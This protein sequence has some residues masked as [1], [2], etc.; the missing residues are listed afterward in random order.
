MNPVTT[1]GGTADLFMTTRWTVIVTACEGSTPEAEAALQQLCQIYWRPL[2][3]YVRH[4]GWTREDAEDLTQALF[5]KLLARA[6][7]AELDSAKGRFRAFLL[8]SLKHFMANEWDKLR[9]QKRGGGVSPLPLDWQNADE[10]YQGMPANDSSPDKL[11]DRAWAITLLD[12]V[13][14][15]LQTE[16]TTA[17]KEKMFQQLKDFLTLESGSIPYDQAAESLHIAAGAARVA[18]HR[19]RKRY[20]ELLRE[21]VAQ[22]LD[23]PALVDQEMSSLF[24]AFTP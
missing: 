14:L 8:A 1:A 13:I 15:R 12:R 19:L 20:R 24:R 18:V 11:Y 16:C 21:E 17:G 2:Y 7:L 3:A 4:Q 6:D 23:N 5:A 9:A 10:L 22:T